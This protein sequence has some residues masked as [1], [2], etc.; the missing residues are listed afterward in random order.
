MS[1]GGSAAP[2]QEERMQTKTWKSNAMNIVVVL[3][4]NNQE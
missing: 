3:L 4:L 1:I 2:M